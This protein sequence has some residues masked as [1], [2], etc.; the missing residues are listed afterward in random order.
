LEQISWFWSYFGADFSKILPKVSL[1]FDFWSPNSQP[2]QVTSPG[3]TVKYLLTVL[4]KIYLIENGRNQ[5]RNLS[6]YDVR[7]RMK[8]RIFPDPVENPDPDAQG[9][10]I[11]D[12][13]GSGS[14]TLVH[15]VTNT[16]LYM[17]DTV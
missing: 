1:K 15:S 10:K 4:K 14:T 9:S 8:S 2:P 17:S 13:S 3:M 11:P 5:M 16:C 12:L 6:F 7:I